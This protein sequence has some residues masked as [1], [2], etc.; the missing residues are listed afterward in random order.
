MNRPLYMNECR[1]HVESKGKE[2]MEGKVKNFSGN[3]DIVVE[4]GSTDERQFLHTILFRHRLRRYGGARERAQ[5]FMQTMMQ[6]SCVVR[7]C[8][9]SH[10]I[11]QLVW[12]AFDFLAQQIIWYLVFKVA[13]YHRQTLSIPLYFFSFSPSCLWKT[14]RE[15][16]LRAKLSKQQRKITTVSQ[17]VLR[18]LLVCRNRQW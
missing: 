4:D 6:T 14:R 16:W 3:K 10:G 8:E 15:T 11:W 9:A 5:Q 18:L 17:K 2:I 7:L 13:C 1:N 12:K